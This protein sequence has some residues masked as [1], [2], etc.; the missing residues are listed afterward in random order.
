MR[1]V[2][3]LTWHSLRRFAGLLLTAGLVLTGF[4]IVL[5]AAAAYLDRSNA[6]S[7]FALLFPPFV[8][9]MMGPMFF[10]ML[11][12]TGVVCLG[13]FHIAV[14][15]TL[16]GLMVALGTEP[17]AEMESG[18]ADLIL[19]KPMPRHV[20]I[21]R[22]IILL[23][24]SVSFLLGVMMA[25]TLTGLAL[26]APPGSV[27]PTPALLVRLAA[28]LGSL[29]LCW[30]SIALAAATCVRRR[31]TAGALV[32]LLALAGFLIVYLGQLWK[33]AEGISRLSPFFYFRML[34]LIV[35]ASFPVHDI[36]ILLAAA[37]CSVVFAYVVYAKRDL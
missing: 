2:A 33:P 16:V 6:F 14:L 1:S 19:A 17:V 29:L 10:A 13:Y 34:N 35:N 12:F 11:S 23:F 27:R 25:G 9:E 36:S 15:S 20:P 18:F 8:R 21:T 3:A 37:L 28:N 30:G 4:Q 32:S 5:V 7:Q 31:A 24:L 22:S 26:L